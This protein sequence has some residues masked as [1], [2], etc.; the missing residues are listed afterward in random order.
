MRTGKKRQRKRCSECRCWFE[1]ARTAEQSQ[2]T[3]S[4]RCREK[5]RRKQAN[6]RRRRDLDG[7]RADERQRQADC[8]ERRRDQGREGTENRHVSRATLSSQE[9]ILRDKI[10]ESWDKLLELSRARFERRVAHL[11]GRSGEKVGQT[12]TRIDERH[13]PP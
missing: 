2:K 8:R 6:R 4:Q 10:I 11:L 13:A 12:E 1:P 5:R 3:C 9:A 7:Y